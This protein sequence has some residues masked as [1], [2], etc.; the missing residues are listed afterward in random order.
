MMLPTVPPK[1]PKTTL[2]T[3]QA[4]RGIAALL[5][6]S[7]HVETTLRENAVGTPWP[8]KLGGLSGFGGV[9]LDIFFVISGFI[10]VYVGT[11]YFRGEGT[12]KDFILRRVLRVYPLYWLVT[13]LLI[14][15]ATAKTL[16]GVVR[17]QSLAQA[18]DFDLQWHRLLGAVTLFPT[19]NEQGNVQPILG[20]GWTLSY[21]V[22][23]YVVFA[24]TLAVGFRWSPLIVTALFAALAF[25]PLP[26]GDSALGNS[27]LGDS[28]LAQFLT[29]P[30]LLEFP[31]G[32]LIGYA[33]VLGLR[34]P[35]WVVTLCLVVGLIGF[36]P[37]ILIDFDYYYHY[38]YR[39]I[40]SALLVFGV[41]FWEIQTRVKVPPFLIKLGDASYAVYLIHHVVI[42]YLVMPVLRAAPSLQ[43]IQVDILGFII[44]MLASVAGV[45]LYQWLEQPL[46]AWLM[47]RYERSP[48]PNPLKNVK[49][50]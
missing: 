27:E 32:M 47:K 42:S 20:V 37:G 7:T 30:V 5:V 24:L 9:G 2:N 15:A 31:M 13:L 43:K 19:F 3:L 17:G 41:I 46:Q 48:K 1:Q 22:F 49:P 6:V 4:L 16:L 23:F 38:L 33:V 11:R 14:G 8:S 45:V 28:A 39:G 25:V 18:L 21:E 34:P 12:I 50:F 35:R 29:N 10:M 44:F 36:L 40:P 26:L